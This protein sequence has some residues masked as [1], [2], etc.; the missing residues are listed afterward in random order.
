MV[1]SRDKVGYLFFAA[2]PIAAGLAGFLIEPRGALLGLGFL[3]MGALHQGISHWVRK[4]DMTRDNW[5]P[6]LTPRAH[7]FLKRLVLT[8]IGNDPIGHKYWGKIMKQSAD[9]IRPNVGPLMNPVATDAFE[10]LCDA[11]NRL[12]GTSKLSDSAAKPM[13][14]A[15]EKSMASGI[16]LVA[17]LD[18]FPETADAVVPRIHAISE[19]LISVCG[20]ISTTSELKIENLTAWRELL[21]STSADEQNSLSQ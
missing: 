7:R 12:I 2:A 6:K 20:E 17:H 19:A 15:A 21:E 4:H 5:A 1:K 8:T 10:G 14:D 11:Y 3:G 16:D 18:L 9:S 13:L